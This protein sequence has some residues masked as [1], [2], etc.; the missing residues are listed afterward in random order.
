MERLV[1][2]GCRGHYAPQR[3]MLTLHRE[4][5]VDALGSPAAVT[6]I[7]APRGAGKTVLVDSW[8]ASPLLDDIAVAQVPTPDP[9][10]AEA[11]YW[12]T[13]VEALRV[14]AGDSIESRQGAMST[15]RASTGVEAVS[16][17]LSAIA[18]DLLL[19][20][21]HPDRVISADLEPKLLELLDAHAG[22]HLVVSLRTST[23]FA[24]A[25][26]RNQR[27]RRICA[28]DLRFT[29]EE[30]ASL[31]AQGG[32]SLPGGLIGELH[33]ALGGSAALVG[34]AANVLWR[35][36]VE[37]PPYKSSWRELRAAISAMLDEGWLDRDQVPPYRDDL[38]GDIWVLAAVLS[39][40]DERTMVE[41][42]GGDV[43]PWLPAI[44]ADFGALLS[45]NLPQGEWQLVPIVRDVV[46]DRLRAT[47]KESPRSMELLQRIKSGLLES[48]DHESVLGCA[49]AI[50]DWDLALSVLQEHWPKLLAH[51][52]LVCDV[53]EALPRDVAA[54][55]AGISAWRSA[56]IGLGAGMIDKLAMIADAPQQ[57]DTDDGSARPLM[58][59]ITLGTA[60]AV[61]HRLAGEFGESSRLASQMASIVGDASSEQQITV[62][63]VLPAMRLQWAISHQLAAQMSLADPE[64]RRAFA[65]A[66]TVQNEAFARTAT[67]GLAMDHALRGEVKYAAEWIAAESRYAEAPGW[68]G[69]RVRVGG[70]V[71]KVIAALDRM[72]TPAAEAALRDLGQPNAT[73]ELWAPMVVARC[74]VLQA[75]GHADIGLDLIT[76]SS[77]TFRRWIT[78]DSLA[79]KLLSITAAHL[80]CALGQGNAALDA[81]SW[82]P[83]DHPATRV[84]RGTV[85]LLGG[86]AAAA[87]AE[88][89][90]ALACGEAPPRVTISALMVAG[91]A[92]VQIGEP[93]RSRRS[94][95]RAT[96]MAWQTGLTRPLLTLPKT[97]RTRLLADGLIERDLE[98]IWREHAGVE[99]TPAEIRLV[100]LTARELAVVERLASGDSLTTIAKSFFISPNTVKSQMR[101]MYRK[102][103]VNTRD[104]AVRAAKGMSLI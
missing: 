76:R 77:S 9:D 94:F 2:Q 58:D 72:D 49:M 93:E 97:R 40:V 82:A 80:Y 68:L 17:H 81:L 100:L 53:L 84:I 42:L 7:Q 23:M 56:L 13:V 102:L 63:S 64:F 73:E 71:A 89:Q 27:A 33:E 25:R 35:F 79:R 19:V 28:A 96:E 24:T 85:F 15:G 95:L 1:P 103:G 98:Q 37:Q 22:L 31:F 91:A 67:G 36:A 59:V 38:A 88:V 4:R 10:T 47:R 48:G 12:S 41:L 16:A 70:L 61:I 90:A 45:G 62:A 55:D 50:E 51:P 14:A 18:G 65:G 30:A 101:T 43:L 6:V 46:L 26:A 11:D 5:L 57:L 60:H 78:E 69:P 20:L 32:V 21:D 87:L 83:P 99:L 8:L 75:Q 92:Q 39:A 3:D 104:D 74:G 66:A 52:Q 86:D 44:I 34:G 54:R 29:R